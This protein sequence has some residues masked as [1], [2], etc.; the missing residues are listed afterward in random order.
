MPSANIEVETQRELSAHIFSVS[1]QLVGI[2]LTV[3]GLFR[4]MIRLQTVGRIADALLALDA[5]AFLPPACAPTPA[6]IRGRG[7]GAERSSIAD[8]CF[9][10]HS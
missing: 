4:V 1:A 6:F 7:S 2:C 9:A 5:V 8:A 3:L 10:S